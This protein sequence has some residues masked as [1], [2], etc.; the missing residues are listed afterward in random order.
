MYK[1]QVKEDGTRQFHTA[2]VEIGKKNGKSELAAAVALYLLY[3]DHE[4]SE[5][6]IRDRHYSDQH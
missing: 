5:M 3:A 4:P 6:C 1:R 2:Y